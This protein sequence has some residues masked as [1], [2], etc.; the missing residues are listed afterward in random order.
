MAETIILQTHKSWWAELWLFIAGF[1]FLAA[2]ILLQNIPIPAILPNLDYI[3]FGIFI[4]FIILA[5]IDHYRILY[6]ITDKRV[7]RKVGIIAKYEK[8]VFYKNV[9]DLRLHQNIIE[10]IL[11]IGGV[12]V[13]TVETGIE[14][15]I[16]EVRNP[17][18]IY[19]IV[20]SYVGGL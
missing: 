12:E 17:E 10:R 2:G 11:G 14:I 15:D 3:P 7:I 20:N 8:S 13:D 1:L 16:D 19:D 4:F 18:N 6:I 9:S 5:I